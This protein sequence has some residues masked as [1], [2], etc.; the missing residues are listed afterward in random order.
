MEGGRKMRDRLIELLKK[1]DKY[2]SGICT[3]YDEAQAVCA[4]YL[5][6]EG[7]IVPNVATAVDFVEVVRCKDCLY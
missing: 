4:E 3:D 6:R 5:I 2:A 7:V 1:A